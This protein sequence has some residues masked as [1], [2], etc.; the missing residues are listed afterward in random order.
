[1]IDDPDGG[2]RNPNALAALALLDAVT[3]R[4]GRVADGARESVAGLAFYRHE[5]HPKPAR[6]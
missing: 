5:T 6:G 3:G 2:G 4:A 1:M